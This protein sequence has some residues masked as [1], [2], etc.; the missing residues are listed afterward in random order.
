[1]NDLSEERLHALLSDR[2]IR[3]HEQLSSTNEQALEWLAQGAAPGSL[4]VADCQTE[5]RGRLGRTWYA[6]PGSSILMTYILHS[7]KALAVRA[8]MIGA[9]AV[10]ETL[11]DLGGR[12]VGLKYPN[13]VQIA[14]RKVAGVLAEAVWGDEVAIAL[15]I[16]LNVR[17][18]FAGTPYVETATSVETALQRPVDRAELLAGIVG[19][20]DFWRARL[21]TTALPMAWRSYL[22][23]LGEWVEV[24]TG[25]ER[26]RGIAAD[27]SPEG[28]L[29]LRDRHGRLREVWA[30]DLL[31]PGTGASPDLDRD[32]EGE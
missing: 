24:H 5:G 23:M 19:R 13:D 15:G 10:A 21:S 11:R 16:G 28:A 7:S 27:V 6:P 20:L 29:V 17:M 22:N 4:V 9:L 32:E 8:T 14:R 12:G 30:G 26:L 31:A 18:D 1:M 3:F 2:A 25:S